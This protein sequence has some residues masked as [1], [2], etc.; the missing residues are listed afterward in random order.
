MERLPSIQS[1]YRPPGNFDGP[2]ASSELSRWWSPFQ[3]GCAC[4]ARVGART[5]EVGWFLFAYSVLP[6]LLAGFTAQ[7]MSWERWPT[8]VT[9]PFSVQFR[10][11]LIVSGCDVVPGLFVS[12]ST[13]LPMIAYG[14]NKPPVPPSGPPYLGP[15]FTMP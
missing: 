14:S 8:M 7:S 6:G 5:L 10:T 3:S 4:F 2:L 13:Y 1:S 15:A 11:A 12:F 9:R